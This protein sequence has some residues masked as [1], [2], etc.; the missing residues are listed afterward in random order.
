MLRRLFLLHVLG[1]AVLVASCGSDGAEKVDAEDWVD[2]ICDA[3]EDLDE[4]EFEAFDDYD[5]VSGDDG[6][7]LREAFY[8]YVDDYGDALDEFAAEAKDAGQPDVRGGDAI[9]RAVQDW[10]AEEKDNLARGERRVKALDEKDEELVAAVDDEFFGMDLADLAEMLEDTGAA[11]A[12]DIIELIDGD[13]NCAGFL[14]A[15]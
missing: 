1:A 14:F 3:V 13:E 4:A 7:D 10:V 15:S 5:A 12:D 9:A 8:D 6:E 2:D 11:D